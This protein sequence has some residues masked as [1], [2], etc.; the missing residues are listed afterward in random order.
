MLRLHTILSISGPENCFFFFALSCCFPVPSTGMARKCSSCGHNGHNSRTCSGNNG[1]GGG[2]GGLRL[3][4]VQLQVGAAPLKKSFSME[5]LSSSAYYAAAAVA[6]SNSSS[7]VSSSSSLVSVE[8]NAEK[9][10]HGYLSDGLMGRAQ[11]R[12]KGVPWTEDEHRRFLAGLEKLGKGDWRGISRH[13]VATRTPTQVASHA[14]KYFL[15]QAGLAQKKRRSSLFDVAEKN[16]DKAAKESRPR[17]KHEA[18]SSVDGMAIRSFPALSL[19]PS[20]PRPA[21]VF[22]PCLT[23]MP[24]CSSPPPPS[25]S[26]AA[27]S[28]ASRAPKLPPS[29]AA[30]AIPPPRQAPD[31][32]LKISSTAAARKTD[33]ASV[34]SS[35]TPRTPFFGTICRVT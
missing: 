12:K 24:S 15:R 9:M 29:I 14:Q 23:L 7:S 31:L 13:F 25:M 18:G 11:E 34:G 22:P 28:M 16:G 17:P 32:E 8:E 6:A 35:P 30:N 33:Q 4:G 2:G 3:F 21:A 1:G 5:C 20:R 19:G 27:L 26:G 10:G